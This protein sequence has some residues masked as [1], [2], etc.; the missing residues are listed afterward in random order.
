MN[1]LYHLTSPPPPLEQTDAVFQEVSLLNSHFGGRRINHFPLS[2]PSRLFPKALY[3]LHTRRQLRAWAATTDIHHVFYVN[4]YLFPFIRAFDRPVVYSIVAGLEGQPKPTALTKVKAPLHIVVSNER[5]L[6]TLT[7]WGITQTALI[8]PAMEATAF[9]HTPAADT[10]EFVLLM[11]S[12]PWIKK[13]FDI[14]GIDI[15]LQAVA[16]KPDLRLILL[17]RGLLFDELQRRI[18][19]YRVGERV[20]VINEKADVN[21]LLARAH[22]AVVLSKS[23]KAV[24]AYPHS[25]LESLAAGKAVM[26]SRAIPMADYIRERDC[27]VVIDQ[28]SLDALLDG[29]ERLQ[30][31]YPRYCAQTRGAVQ[32]DFSPRQFIQAYNELYTTILPSPSGKKQ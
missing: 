29:I 26:T 5:D 23:A 6:R 13:Q 31:G 4:L 30:R 2:S 11:G 27:G 15:L 19:N 12:A 3:G 21:E 16:S 1:I 7:S 18:N 25:L 17:W 32:E 8:R 22:A 9:T 14:K 10:G 28:V 24:K 20:E